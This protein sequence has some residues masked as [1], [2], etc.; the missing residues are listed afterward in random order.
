MNFVDIIVI[1]ILILSV[2]NGFR[3]GVINS[4]MS[5]ISTLLVFII[6][7]Y[8]KNP[9]SLLL[10]NYLPFFNLGGIFEGVTAYNIL[11]FEGISYLITISLLSI[12]LGVVAKVTGVISKIIN[13]TI[14]VGIPSRILGLLVGA[15]QGFIFAF[16]IV[17]IFSLINVTSVKVKES[18]YGNMMLQN[19]PILSHIVK[20]TSDSISEIIDIIRSNKNTEEANYQAL[21]VLLEHE[22]ISPESAKKLF[23]Q[24]KLNIEG[25]TELISKY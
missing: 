8:L 21:K 3:K 14:V 10:Y 5:F 20:D 6:A 16:I 7:F 25:A 12:I 13:N 11:I 22:I 1:A 23:D 15:L 2:L 24:G 18:K 9:I 19:T 17:F 4:I